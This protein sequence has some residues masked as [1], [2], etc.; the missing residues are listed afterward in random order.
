[1]G[2]S[3]ISMA[4]PIAMLVYQRVRYAKG[5]FVNHQMCHFFLSGLLNGFEAK[6]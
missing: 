2:K 3:T 6:G 1:M 4:I 5:V